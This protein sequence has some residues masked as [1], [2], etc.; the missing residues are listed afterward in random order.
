MVRDAARAAELVD[1]SAIV[2]SDMLRRA[3]WRAAAAVAVLLLVVLVASDRARQSYDALALA[4]FPS[5]I[6]LDVTPGN[7]RVQAGSALAIE[8]RLVGNTAPVVAQLLPTSGSRLKWKATAPGAS[9]WRSR[10]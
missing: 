10:G 3:A 4:L 8:A 5:R 2:T 1:P 9:A 6:E 7:T